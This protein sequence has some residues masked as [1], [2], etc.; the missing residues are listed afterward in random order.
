M[1][2]LKSQSLQQTWRSQ[3]PL[4]KCEALVYFEYMYA[5]I[6]VTL[7]T[8]LS[9]FALVST[10]LRWFDCKSL[11]RIKGQRAEE[12]F[13]EQETVMNPSKEASVGETQSLK[14]IITAFFV[15]GLV[16]CRCCFELGSITDAAL[17]S[18]CEALL[19]RNRAERGKEKIG[20][21]NQRI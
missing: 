20:D 16:D 8:C 18:C 1:L 13:W 10:C 6:R 19:F 9:A 5:R 4:G 2:V 17:G 14:S 12:V 11:A 3:G 7:W 15:L 21:T